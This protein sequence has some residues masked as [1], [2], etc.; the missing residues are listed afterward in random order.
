MSSEAFLKTI[1]FKKAPTELP[2]DVTRLIKL[3]LSWDPGARPTTKEAQK[4]VRKI[5][6]MDGRESARDSGLSSL[7]DP[8]Q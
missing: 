4:I 6:R 7:S 2:K 1:D 5:L 3:L 8:E